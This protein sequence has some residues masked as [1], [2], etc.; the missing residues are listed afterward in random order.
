MNTNAGFS[1]DTVAHDDG[2]VAIFTVHGQT[3]LNVVGVETMHA[4]AAGVT[5]MSKDPTVRCAV[6]QGAPDAAFIGGA[7]LRELQ[8]LRPHNAAGFVGAIHEF[9]ASLRAFPVPVIARIRGHCLGAGMEI[10]AACDFRACDE[11]AVFGMPEVRVGVPSVVEATLLPLLIGHGK[12]RELVLRGH[13][14]DAEE[15][16]RIGFIEQYVGKGDV[17]E[18]IARAVDDIVEAAPKA[19]RLQKR[20]CNAWEPPGVDTAIADSLAAFAA[21]Y[22]T[23][24][25]EQYC[26]RFFSRRAGG[27]KP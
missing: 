26:E 24:E 2:N 19:I 23:G 14:I 6:L 16:F 1:C 15:A 10:A 4:C 5:A 20:L 21:A 22:E 8:G 18:A 9:C 12:T 11:S 25:P 17:D 3:R 13:L 7:N 27:P